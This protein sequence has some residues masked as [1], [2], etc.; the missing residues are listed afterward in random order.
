M[1]VWA[2]TALSKPAE[3]RGASAVRGYHVAPKRRGGLRPVRVPRAERAP[4]RT[5]GASKFLSRSAARIGPFSRKANDTASGA[6]AEEEH[7]E[8]E[9]ENKARAK[10][11][12]GSACAED[13][14]RA[15]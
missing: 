8:Q 3:P 4:R 11:T 5:V 15:P 1:T 10:D 12:T 14:S 6:C 13:P 7:D 9:E 2:H